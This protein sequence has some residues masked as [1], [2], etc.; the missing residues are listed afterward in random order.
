MA[1]EMYLAVGIFVLT[2]FLMVTEIIHRTVAVIFGAML[3]VGFG[4]LDQH[5]MF[6]YIEFEALGL[7]FGMF[8]IV[9][10]LSQSGFFRWVGLHA[11]HWTKF[12]PLKIFIV[13]SILSAVMAAFM[14]SITVLIFMAALVIEVCRILKVP[15][16]PF[17]LGCITSANIGG[18]A[19]MVGDPPNIVIGTA[20]NYGFMD[21][22][23]NTGPIA[24][25]VF[26]VNITFFYFW[27]RKV[28]HSPEE[29][30][31]KIFE[32]HKDLDPH[33]AVEDWH[34]MNIA[35]GIFAFTITL[36]IF[37]GSLEMEVSFVGITGASLV[38]IF[39]GRDKAELVE[40]IDWLTIIF[41]AALFIMVG[42]LKESG[43]L[44]SVATSIVDFG[45]GN[46]ALI[47]TV[48]LWVS[49]IA[50]A[51]L[52]NVPFAA[53][54][55]SVIPEVSA[56]TGFAL[57][58]MAFTLALGCDIGGNATPIGASANVVG[59]SVA[60]KHGENIS[61]KDYMKSAFPAMV[62]SMAIINVLIFVFLM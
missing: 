21:F 2:L 50:S 60:Q 15:V 34:L 41:L 59:L 61:W 23:M 29:D 37:H 54:M 33:E 58:P 27:F 22:V 24:V 55:V 39:G 10:A 46:F 32:E 47:L 20:L 17:L 5:E 44:S 43:F 56:Q 16:L 14:D 13:F 1:L 8:I 53:A 40:K 38:L 9:A 35:L 62:I 19:T 4:I 7:I 51:F 57:S 48:I 6:E 52:D 12:N 36:L 25:I 28:F 31:E 45:G 42:G 18:S 26:I 30:I 49:A 11:L 3:M